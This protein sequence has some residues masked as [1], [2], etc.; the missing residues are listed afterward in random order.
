MRT[1][2]VGAL[3]CMILL[4][5][6]I[7]L[8]FLGDQ[9]AIQS[10]TGGVRVAQVDTSRYPDVTV[11]VGVEDAAGQTRPNLR[12]NDF[13]L[14][15]DG[16]PVAVSGFQAAGAVN[17]STLLL[18]DCSA[19]M[20]DDGRLTGAQEAAQ[21]YV[22]LMRPGDQTA[23]MTF[24]GTQSPMIQPFTSDQ[25]RLERAIDRIDADG[26]TPLYDGLVHAVDVL[27]Q[28]QGR[29]ALILLSDGQ[30]CR[31]KPCN[32][33]P[34]SA[35]T[36]D[37]VIARAQGTSLDVQAIGLGDP[38][39]DSFDEQVLQRIAEQTGGN[40]FH[41]PSADD[42]A[43]LYATLGGNLHS[44]Y[45][46]TYTSPRATYDG[47]R[48]TIDVAVDGGRSASGYVEEHLINVQSNGIVGVLLLI[49]LVG[50]LAA[51]TVMRRRRG[52]PLALANSG[53][54]ATGSDIPAF[55]A[56][57]VLQPTTNPARGILVQPT[58]ATRRCVSCGAAMRAGA[59][60]CAACGTEQP[61]ARTSLS[62]PVFCDQ[63]GHAMLPN[64]RFCMDCGATSPVASDA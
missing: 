1:F 57:P 32:E 58:A 35:T 14:T 54:M 49:P 19:S 5:I 11:Y 38:G 59:R 7:G 33:H 36:L 62:Q 16:V 37:Q 29:R 30:D 28:Q 46:L 53:V 25:E 40:Y 8:F 9:P 43:A 13:V 18:L 6:G 17:V 45:A 10:S 26:S 34:G 27:A 47:T 21:R 55:A 15:E 31:E 60:F 52:V 61:I 12:Q 51:P 23:V 41:A 48:R 64:A 42:L 3:L 63:C 20:G 4:G 39:D 56:M 24:C 50:A 44:E 22:E 2:I